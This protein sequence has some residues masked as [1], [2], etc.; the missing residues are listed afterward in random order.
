VASLFESLAAASWSDLL[1]GLGSMLGLA[2]FIQDRI[3]CYR[4]WRNR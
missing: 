2:C 3:D 4:R 1:L